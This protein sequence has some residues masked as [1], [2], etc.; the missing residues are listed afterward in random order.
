[1]FMHIQGQGEV[2]KQNRVTQREQFYIQGRKKFTSAKHGHTVQLNKNFCRV[3]ISMV[4][5][6]HTTTTSTVHRVTIPVAAVDVLLLLLVLLYSGVNSVI[7]IH[8]C[9]FL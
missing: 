2:H 7:V 6:T 3:R 9:V 5:H 4:S 1:M 8:N